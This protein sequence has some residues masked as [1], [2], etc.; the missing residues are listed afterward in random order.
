[1]RTHDKA[2][3]IPT[4]ENGETAPALEE[5]GAF[6]LMSQFFYTCFMHI[7]SKMLWRSPFGKSVINSN[8]DRGRMQAAKLAIEITTGSVKPL[9]TYPACKELR[10]VSAHQ[11]DLIRKH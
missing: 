4:G 6:C 3:W 10:H 9:Y 11:L 1:M 5:F 8:R 7:Q 2:V